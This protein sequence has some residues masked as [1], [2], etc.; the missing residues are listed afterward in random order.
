MVSCTLGILCQD[1]HLFSTAPPSPQCATVVLLSEQSRHTLSTKP[2]KIELEA[3]AAQQNTIFEGVI[4]VTRLGSIPPCIAD[5][6]RGRCDFHLRCGRSGV[7]SDVNIFPAVL[8]IL[9][10]PPS[11]H[12]GN[13]Q[14]AVG[15]DIVDTK[16]PVKYNHRLL[17]TRSTPYLY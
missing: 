7:R 17:S 15:K 8:I 10:P 5:D 11:S 16:F 3:I 2:L 13:F 12:L 6:N 1:H 9:V 4:D 14:N